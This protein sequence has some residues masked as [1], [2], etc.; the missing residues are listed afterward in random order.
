LAQDSLVRAW[1]GEEKGFIDRVRISNTQLSEQE[2]IKIVKKSDYSHILAFYIFTNQDHYLKRIKILV[3]CDEGGKYCSGLKEYVI[4]RYGNSKG[5]LSFSNISETQRLRILKRLIILK[6]VNPKYR[7]V[8]NWLISAI[9]NTNEV[10]SA[11][12]Q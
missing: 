5:E 9:A 4:Q 11:N 2:A 8:S 6:G 12:K 10:G 1:Y 3:K 7:L